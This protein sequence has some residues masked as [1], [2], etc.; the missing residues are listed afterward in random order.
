MA[1]ASSPVRITTSE[2]CETRCGDLGDQQRG[3]RSRPAP[4]RSA[5]IA[6]TNAGRIS[7]AEVRSTLA[8]TSRSAT[9]RSTRSPA[10]RG[11]RGEQQRGVHRVVELGLV[12]DPAG[13]GAAGVEHDQHV[14]VPFG[15]PGPHHHRG[16]PGRAAPVDGAHVV[17]GHVLAQAVELGALAALQDGR[18][19]V[20]LAQPGQPAGQVLAGVERR[21]RADGPRRGVLGLA[22]GHAQRAEGPDHHRPGVAG[23]RAGSAA[24]SGSAGAAAGRGCHPLRPRRGPRPTAS[25]RCG[26]CRRS[27]G[28]PVL[29]EHQL[30]A[31]PPRRAGPRCRRTA[32]D[33]RPSPATAPSSD[34]GRDHRDQHRRWRSAP[35]TSWRRPPRP[36]T[37][38]RPAARPA[39]SGP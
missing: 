39:R 14:P 3:G 1:A 4:A 20:E 15:P 9:S 23:R 8:R 12:A 27:S 18:P 7:A 16:G 6:L 25:R 10:R 21:Q 32:A 36:A 5:A 37:P 29:V 17:A 22:A 24:G 26:P 35:P 28:V 30:G 34:V 19:A 38:A 13:R 11:Q 31:A 33:L 2:R